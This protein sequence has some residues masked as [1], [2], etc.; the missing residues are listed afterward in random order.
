MTKVPLNT[1]QLNALLIN[2]NHSIQIGFKVKHMI[3]P[4]GLG[5]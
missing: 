5:D 3:K 4:I 2:T 1:S